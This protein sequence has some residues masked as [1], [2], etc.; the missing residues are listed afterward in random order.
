MHRSRDAAAISKSDHDHMIRTDSVHELEF[1]RHGLAGRP[2]A[3]H[4][5]C[6]IDIAAV[7]REVDVNLELPNCA[8]NWP[9][10][11]DVCDA[12][13]TAVEQAGKRNE[14]EAV[15]PIKHL[16][17]IQTAHLAE[18]GHT[19]GDGRSGIMHSIVMCRWV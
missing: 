5:A 7:D 17:P 18:A 2:G 15:A 6:A 11:V 12:R 13:M 14:L 4:A 10:G 1:E 8:C 3:A 9:S 16:Q 19:R